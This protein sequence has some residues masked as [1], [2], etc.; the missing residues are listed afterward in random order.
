MYEPVPAEGEDQVGGARGPI[1]EKRHGRRTILEHLG[2][3][4]TDAQLAALMQIG[5]EKLAVNQP[6][7][8]LDDPARS[9]PAA[10]GAVVEGQSSRLLKQPSSSNGSR[11]EK[12]H[13]SPSISRSGSAS[14]RRSPRS[15]PCLGCQEKRATASV[16]V[17]VH[18]AVVAV[19]HQVP[20]LAFVRGREAPALFEAAPVVGAQWAVE[21]LLLAP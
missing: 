19:A 13:C 17:A 1:V 14:S 15:S 20:H 16:L 5:R 6:A 10:G 7:L 9:R 4:H 3:A 2:S 8:D 11:P 18:D 21:G 12:R